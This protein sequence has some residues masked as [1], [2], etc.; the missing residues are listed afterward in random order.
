MGAARAT[1]LLWAKNYRSRSSDQSKCSPL[2]PT[3]HKPCLHLT[4]THHSTSFIHVCVLTL[5][6][7][8]LVSML[9]VSRHYLSSGCSSS[10]PLH[11]HGSH[12]LPHSCLGSRS[13]CNNGQLAMLPIARYQLSTARP[14]CQ[15][16]SVVSYHYPLLLDFY[17]MKI[18]K[19]QDQKKKQ[20][21]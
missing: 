4:H 5:S 1:T 21:G 8:C 9:P 17:A 6:T 15:S 12:P 20:N 18:I 19:I 3:T 16:W 13:I 10:P 14:P 2:Q 7:R 11:D